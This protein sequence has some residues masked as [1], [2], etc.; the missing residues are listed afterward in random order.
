MPP[1]GSAHHSHRS[2]ADPSARRSPPHRGAAPTYKRPDS[3]RV[4]SSRPRGRRRSTRRS[5]NGSSADLHRRRR[6]SF[7]SRSSAPALRAR[8]R[9]LPAPRRRTRTRD[10]RCPL[11][12]TPAALRSR[13]H[14]RTPVRSRHCTR[15]PPHQERLPPRRSHRVPQPARPNRPALFF[16][17]APRPHPCLTPVPPRWATIVALFLILSRMRQPPSTSASRRAW[18][19]APVR[20]AEPPLARSTRSSRHSARSFVSSERASG[21]ACSRPRLARES[22]SGSYNS[23]RRAGRTPRCARS[24]V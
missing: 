10:S 4:R 8:S 6:S 24:A 17:S 2:S 5:E 19:R 16:A 23:S 12:C 14:T 11:R 9:R 1:T 21:S 15:G 18:L 7:G 20:S 22:T 3:S 13:R